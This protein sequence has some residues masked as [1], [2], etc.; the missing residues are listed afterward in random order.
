[1]LGIAYTPSIDMWSFGCIIIE[2]YTGYPIFPGE[3][4]KEQLLLIMETLGPPPED[5][6]AISTRTENFFNP[7]NTPKLIENSRG[8]TRYPGA[9]TLQAT[10]KTKSTSF[11]DFITRCLEWD[12]RKRLTP[13]EAMQHDWIQNDVS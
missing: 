4:E 7:D 8:K 11:Y 3:S 5:L 9:K 1:M 10:L 6:L 12:Y 2:L 13:E